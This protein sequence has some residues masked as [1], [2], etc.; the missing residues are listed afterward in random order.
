VIVNGLSIGQWL[1]LRDE[2]IEDVDPRV[3]ESIWP[4]G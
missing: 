3:L 4:T 1:L 2:P